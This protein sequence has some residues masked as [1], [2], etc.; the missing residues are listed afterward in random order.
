MGDHDHSIYAR[1]GADINTILNFSKSFPNAT[2]VKLEQ[3][4]RSTKTILDAAYNVVSKNQHRAD[5]K[6][7][8]DNDVGEL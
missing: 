5:K 8:T 6:L 4:Y 3:N 1:R 2:T 7:W